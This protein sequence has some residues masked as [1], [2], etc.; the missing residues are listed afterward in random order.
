LEAGSL[1][2]TLF[3]SAAALKKQHG[4]AARVHQDEHTHGKHR[5]PSANRFCQRLHLDHSD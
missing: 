3:T 1:A 2:F 5:L 4:C